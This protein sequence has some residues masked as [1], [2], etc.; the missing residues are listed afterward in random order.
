MVD[1]LEQVRLNKAAVKEGHFDTASADRAYAEAFRD[2]GIDV[3]VLSAEEAA[4]RIRARAIRVE[5]AAALDDWAFV[6]RLTREKEDATWKE[7]LALARAADPDEL[8]NR[9]REAR[10][11]TDVEAL[12]KMAAPA[13]AAELPA[14]T[15]VVLGEGLANVG[16]VEQAVA[17]LREGQRRHPGNFWINHELAYTLHNKL[18]PGHLEETVRYYTG[19]VA[20][21][22]MSP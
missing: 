6:C 2:Y 4:G 20:L 7:R 15:L 17:V 22:P 13:V 8:R 18:A 3:T 21:R 12:K 5:L 19:A 11:H 1:K 14:A 9:L 10:E 16:A